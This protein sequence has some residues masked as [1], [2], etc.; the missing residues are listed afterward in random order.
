MLVLLIAVS[1]S[2]VSHQRP[3]AGGGNKVVRR[4][5][6]DKKG[7]LMCPSPTSTNRLSPVMQ[8]AHVPVG[9]SSCS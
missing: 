9:S 4:Q 3:E 8:A 1:S 5:A 2:Q 7:E 6:E